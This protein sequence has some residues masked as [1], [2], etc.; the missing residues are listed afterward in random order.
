MENIKELVEKIMKYTSDFSI[1][2]DEWYHNVNDMRK[3]HD[4]KNGKREEYISRDEFDRAVREETLYD[5]IYKKGT[6]LKRQMEND[7]CNYYDE[8]TYFHNASKEL[9]KE[10]QKIITN[11]KIDRGDDKNE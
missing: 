8:E 6:D 2:S 3:S 5:L 11:F 7:L 9:E 10:V 1:S 4:Y